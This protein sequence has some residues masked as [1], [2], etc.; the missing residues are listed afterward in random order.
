MRI[1][2]A[3][4]RQAAAFAAVGVAATATH[5]AVALVAHGALGAGD[6]LANFL[7]YVG[8]VGVSYVGN[9]RITFLRPVRHRGQML[10]FAV[11]SLAG[12]ALGQAIIWAT[13]RKLGLPF[14][15]ALVP[16]V[17]LVPVFSFGASRLWAFAARD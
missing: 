2:A 6:F 4:I 17:I 10:R 1:G 7:G 13:T 12:L 9:A 3:L 8:A 16:V 11:V 5:A 15:V 14:P